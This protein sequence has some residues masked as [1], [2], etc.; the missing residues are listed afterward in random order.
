VAVGK[1]IIFTRFPQEV[2]DHVAGRGEENLFDLEI[3][4]FDLLT[5]D[6]LELYFKLTPGSDQELFVK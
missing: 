3:F 4:H 6:L 1:G 5:F 2:L